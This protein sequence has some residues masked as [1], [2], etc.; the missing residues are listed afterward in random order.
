M[1]TSKFNEFT[2]SDSS[3]TRTNNFRY[4]TPQKFYYLNNFQKGNTNYLNLSVS[5]PNGKQLTSEIN[6]PN[7][8]LYIYK[9]SLVL[10]IESDSLGMTIRWSLNNSTE[11]VYFLPRML[12]YY[13]NK[14]DNTQIL[15]VKE[16]P[17][18][19]IKQDTSDVLVYPKIRYD[20]YVVY[21]K[22]IVDKVLLNIN[23]GE[24]RSNIIISHGI[25]QLNVLEE[26]LARYYSSVNTYNNSYSIKVYEPIITNIKGGFGVFGAYF[27][28]EVPINLDEQFFT[29]LGYGFIEQDIK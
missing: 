10:P 4:D 2:F 18:D 19:Y 3:I 5:L 20:N 8:S 28:K 25:F 15:H 9:N 23:E 27:K 16:I 24:E 6:I 11:I 1:L 12:I 14:N 26:N 17:I 13:Y 7:Y 21:P 22:N 29:D